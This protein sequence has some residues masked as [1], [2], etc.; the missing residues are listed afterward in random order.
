MIPGFCHL[1]KNTDGSADSLAA[2]KAALLL[3]HVAVLFSGW[4]HW[5]SAQAVPTISWR[6]N[7]AQ[8]RQEAKQRQLPLVLDF[9]TEWC[10]HCQRMDATTFQD[11]TIISLLAQHFIPVK[12]DASRE[13]TL[14]EALGIRGY[15]TLVL[16][17]PDGRIVQTLEG[18]Q[19]AGQLAAHL[20]RVL[21]QMGTSNEYA[22]FLEQA[23]QQQAAG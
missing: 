7:Y 11:A 18:Y 8:A 9:T 4:F 15:P 22:R 16:A 13:P 10:V 6:T 20:R 14:V 17:L 3:A 5:L 2:S 19:D 12:I 21:A 1:G 23:K